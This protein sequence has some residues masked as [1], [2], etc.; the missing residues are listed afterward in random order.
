M[1]ILFFNTYNKSYLSDFF[2]E[3]CSSLS[4]L[5]HDV[6]MVSLKQQDKKFTIN[7]KVVVNI[8]KKEKRYHNYYTLF[9]LIKKEKPDVVISNFSY[10]NPVV[11]ASKLLGVRDNIIWFHTLKKQMDFKP[12]NIYIKSK[13]MN[14]ASAIITNSTE[15]K[16]EVIKEYHQ[17]PKKVH[18]LPFTTSVA[19]T[20]KKEVNLVK[21]T[22]NIYIGCPGRIHPDKNQNLLI[23]VLSDLNNENLILV[24][25]GSKQ[26]D[27]LEH[28]K[29]YQRIKDKIIHLGNLSRE[30]MVDFYH[31]MDVIVLPSLNEAFG[32]VLIEALA[33]G[34]NTLV[35]SRFGALDYIQEDVSEM[36]FNP[37][38]VEDLKNKLKE[39]LYNKK[40]TQ[41][42]KDLYENNF[43]LNEI[44]K[45]LLS[46]I[47]KEQLDH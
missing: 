7:S 28:H 6:M 46:I 43:S 19:A 34:C 47:D 20:A 45:Q 27:F 22:N 26:S 41:Y 39:T 16:R 2:L 10:A 14:L 31:K 44:V 42:Y 37:H 24:F 25:A 5:G 35:S 15:L 13:F 11:L 29:N 3:I 12:S 21:A 1:K 17:N 4:S 32:L 38:D 36:T 40:P 33:S 18:N 9:K 23:D 8:L 30:E